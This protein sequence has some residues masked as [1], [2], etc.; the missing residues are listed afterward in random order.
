MPLGMEGNIDEKYCV[1]LPVIISVSV[2][3]VG[4]IVHGDELSILVKIVQSYACVYLS[5]LMVYV[6]GQKLLGEFEAVMRENVNSMKITE[7]QEWWSHRRALNV[8]LG[9]ITVPLHC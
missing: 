1:R 8:Q 4:I 3:S 6:Q 2:Y 5:Q 7:K 9:V